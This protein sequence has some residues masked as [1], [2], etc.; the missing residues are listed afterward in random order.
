MT[1]P[2]IPFKG[3][4]TLLYKILTTEPKYIIFLA[5]FIAVSYFF[6]RFIVFL[7]YS[8]ITGFLVTASFYWFWFDA[9]KHPVTPQLLNMWRFAAVAVSLL[10]FAGAYA[11]DI[12]S[13]KAVK[14]KNIQRSYQQSYQYQ[15]SQQYSQHQQ[16]Q[17]EIYIPQQYPHVY[18][19]AYYYPQ[20]PTNYPEQ[21]TKNNVPDQK[22][23]RRIG[24]E[25]PERKG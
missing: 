2:G 16:Y 5:L 18:Q 24:F 12:S 14:E 6:T 23:K 1:P 17:P 21:N 9:L 11:Y 7:Y 3:I 22:P 19:P 20:Q 15:Q 13:K 4:L 8:F 25:Y 10:I